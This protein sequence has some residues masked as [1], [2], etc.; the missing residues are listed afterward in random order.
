MPLGGPADTGPIHSFVWFD[1]IDDGRER[2]QPFDGF[3][4]MSS[5]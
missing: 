2:I 5:Y 3:N 1:F 4:A